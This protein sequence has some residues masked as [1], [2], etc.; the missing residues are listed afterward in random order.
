MRVTAFAATLLLAS[1]A[2]AE[3]RWLTIPRPAP[4]PAAASTGMA[5]VNG[6]EMYYATYG[7][8]DPVLLI[9]GDLDKDL[10]QPQ[11]LFAALYRQNKDAVLV[12]YRGEG[13]IIQGP[14]NVRDEYDR[15]FGF[16]DRHLR[17]GPQDTPPSR[18]SSDTALQ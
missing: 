8:G 10:S 15:V 2:L 11:G 12:T 6:I 14:A 1:P 18:P 5:P 17:P 7:A 13:H 16:L 9:H 4:M 3:D